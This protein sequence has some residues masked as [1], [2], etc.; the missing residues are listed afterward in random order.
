RSRRG[1]VSSTGTTTSGPLPHLPGH[2]Y[3]D[4]RDRDRYLGQSLG[5]PSHHGSSSLMP[6]GATLSPVHSGSLS[7]AYQADGMVP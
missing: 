7:G 4:A 5:A 1:S 6:V 3:T 2:V